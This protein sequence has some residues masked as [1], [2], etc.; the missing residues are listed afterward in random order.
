MSI[1]N[2][3]EK[4]CEWYFAPGVN[5]NFGPT[6]AAG[7]NFEGSWESLIRECIQNSLDAESTFL[8]LIQEMVAQAENTVHMKKIPSEARHRQRRFAPNWTMSK[9]Q[10]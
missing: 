8:R 10:P 9:E 3:A 4:G 6:D 7:Q 1:I 5:Y 2:Q